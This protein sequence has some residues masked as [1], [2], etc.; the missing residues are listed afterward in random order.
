MSMLE[1]YYMKISYLGPEASYT[2]ITAL[3]VFP[4]ADLIPSSTIT[5]I[6]HDL[7]SGIVD[8]AIVPVENSIAGGVAETIDAL[9]KTEDIYVVNEYVLP[10]VHCLLAT[11]N[12]S[13]NF[14][15]IKRVSAHHMALGQC[16]DFIR[17][18]LPNA[19]ITPKSSN[20]SAAKVLANKFAADQDMSKEVVI[21]SRHCADIYNLELIKEGINDANINET[22]FWVLSKNPEDMTRSLRRSAPQ[23]DNFKQKSSVLFETSNEPGSLQTVLRLFAV[24]HVNLSRIESRPAK[25]SIGIYQF[26]VDFDIHKDDP[27]FDE[28]MRQAKN[29]FSYYKWLGSYEVL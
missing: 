15:E 22:R 9:Q 29:H 8:R 4:E 23:D 17:Q 25:K 18:S 26:L 13:G 24:N 2:H 10:I 5:N 28:L 12:F 6:I 20:S 11:K 3:K 7:D 1:F 21:A 16:M 14:E 27:K 19:E